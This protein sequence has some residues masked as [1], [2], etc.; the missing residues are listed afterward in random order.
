MNYFPFHVGDY[1]GAT[2]H[3]SWDEDMAYTRLLRAYYMTELPIPLD[4]AYR[5]ARATTPAQRRAVD[6]VL[7]EFFCKTTD[8]YTQGRCDAEIAKFQDKQNKAKRSADARWKP[9]Q[10]NSERNANAYLDKDAD[11]MRTHSDGNANQEPITNNQEPKEEDTGIP[12]APSRAAAV[13]VVLK[14]A[15]I[16][17]V[18]PNHPKLLELLASGAVVQDFDDGARI[19]VANG[20]GFAYALGVVEGIRADAKRPPKPS[21][22]GPQAETF[23]ERDARLAAERMAEFAPGVARKTSLASVPTPPNFDPETIDAEVTHVAAIASH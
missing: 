1:A 7:E 8:G 13:C 10:T 12:T 6:T 3:L 16:G 11:G 2:A 17:S 5:L 19:A 23:R 22:N 18:N 20:K 14:S 15:G 21:P 9:S 4:K